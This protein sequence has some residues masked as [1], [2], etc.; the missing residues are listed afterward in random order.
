MIYKQIQGRKKLVLKG[1]RKNNKM[2]IFNFEEKNLELDVNSK[3][4]SCAT[5][6]II[7]ESNIKEKL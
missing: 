1:S 7:G 5:A 3:W 6:M 4:R 2:C